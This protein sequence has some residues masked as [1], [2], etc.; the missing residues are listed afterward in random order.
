MGTEGLRKVEEL[1]PSELMTILSSFEDMPDRPLTV[2]AELYG[3]SSVGIIRLAV[4][5]ILRK[6]LILEEAHSD[7]QI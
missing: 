4:E 7:N 5:H 2:T 1:N 3:L 6:R